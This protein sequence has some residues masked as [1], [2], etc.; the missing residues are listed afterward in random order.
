MNNLT[1]NEIADQ[2]HEIWDE[3]G[4]DYE[5]DWLEVPEQVM[6][7]E[8]ALVMAYVYK[9]PGHQTW[10][11]ADKIAVAT[12]VLNAKDVLKTL[13]ERGIIEVTVEKKDW[14]TVT[15]RTVTPIS[16]WN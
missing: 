12:M 8:E 6:T 15:V 5:T 10:A 13:E 14:G 2:W 11:S 4:Y 7:F 3:F 9:W 1:V 16:E